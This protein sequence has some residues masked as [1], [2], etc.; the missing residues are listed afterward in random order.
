VTED[1]RTSRNTQPPARK[2]FTITELLVVLSIVTILMAVMAHAAGKFF[3]KRQVAAA[4][5]QAATQLHAARNLAVTRNRITHVRFVHESAKRQLIQVYLLDDAINCLAKVT[6]WPDDDKAEDIPDVPLPLGVRMDPD[7]DPTGPP[8]S[9][10]AP[11]GGAAQQLGAIYFW[12]DGSAGEAT[13]TGQASPQPLYIAD[14][15]ANH[16]RVD[17]DLAT[18]RVEVSNPGAQ[19]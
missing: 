1:S 10:Y 12:P 17:L 11:P 4:A 8:E 9:D 3:A 19:Q 13:D 15:F 14:E 16:R 18:G 2:G 6:S 7:G 5:V